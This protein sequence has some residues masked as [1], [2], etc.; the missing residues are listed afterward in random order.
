MCA[1]NSGNIV[2]YP[3]KETLI[4]IGHDCH[5]PTYEEASRLKRGHSNIHPSA[6]V[7]NGCVASCPTSHALAHDVSAALSFSFCCF[8]TADRVWTEQLIVLTTA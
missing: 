1:A 5:P 3:R 2:Q 8:L 7:V 4:R 6:R